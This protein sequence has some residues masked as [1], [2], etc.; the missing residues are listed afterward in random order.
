MPTDRRKGKVSKIRVYKSAVRSA[1]NCKE[2]IAH[3]VTFPFMS[4]LESPHASAEGFRVPQLLPLP[5]RYVPHRP[6]PLKL[7]SWRFA[8]FLLRS[9]QGPQCRCPVG[10]HRCQKEL[11]TRDLEWP[12]LMAMRA[13]WWL[14]GTQY[15]QCFSCFKRSKSKFYV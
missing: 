1:L 12:G 8:S 3:S 5:G 6:L 9:A 15:R 4:G 11:G 10:P 7:C 14:K 2:E 13:P